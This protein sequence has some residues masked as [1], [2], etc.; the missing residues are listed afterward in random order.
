MIISLVEQLEKRLNDENSSLWWPSFSEILVDQALERGWIR[1]VNYSTTQFLISE[2]VQPSLLYL[3]ESTN[4]MQS[5]PS[6]RIECLDTSL[7]D[8]FLQKGIDLYQS[9][10]VESNDFI[11]VF[12]DAADLIAQVP[13][14]AKSVDELAKSVHIIHQPDPAYDISF[15]DPTIP[16]SIFVSVPPVA[17]NGALRTAE[18]I[19]HESM[20]LQLS[21]V[22]RSIDLILEPAATYYSPWKKEMRPVSGVLHAL[23]VFAVIEQWLTHLPQTSD[24]QAYIIQRRAQLREE[25]EQ[26]DASSCLGSLTPVGRLLLSRTMN[27]LKLC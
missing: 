21:L 22:E 10:E 19:I 27:T 5:I 20:H 23:Y 9:N 11:Q 24:N 15:S 6:L 25:V 1:S 16:F 2:N 26:I 18:A 3:I 8:Y 17:F 4:D 12:G 13:S 14:L 7:H